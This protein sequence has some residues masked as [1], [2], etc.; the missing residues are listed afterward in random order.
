MNNQTGAVLFMKKVL[1]VFGGESS[2][3]DVSLV[4]AKSIV[5][6]MPS[7]AYETLCMGITKDGRWYLYSGSIE[8]NNAGGRS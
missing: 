3:H 7:D 1:V 6:N 4:S 8:K 5:E 2:E